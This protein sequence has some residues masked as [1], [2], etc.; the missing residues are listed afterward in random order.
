M[1]ESVRHDVEKQPKMVRIKEDEPLRSQD[2]CALPD[3]Q[4]PAPFSGRR[5]TIANLWSPFPEGSHTGDASKSMPPPSSIPPPPVTAARRMSVMER[6]RQYMSPQP[7]NIGDGVATTKQNNMGIKSPKF[8]F[9][10]M[11]SP[12]L[13]VHAIAIVNSAA[14]HTIAITRVGGKRKLNAL[15]APVHPSRNDK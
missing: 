6:M 10:V 12:V 11:P 15:E 9:P 5:H 8:T 13:S 7:R 3:Q 2:T 14:A 4:R 1:F